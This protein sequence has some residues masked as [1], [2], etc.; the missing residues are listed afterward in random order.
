MSD[1]AQMLG[2]TIEKSIQQR[3]A[4]TVASKRRMD[5]FMHSMKKM[6][7]K[8]NHKMHA[9]IR[10]A[11]PTELQDPRFPPET[12]QQYSDELLSS[13]HQASFW[14]ENNNASNEE[15]HYE[16]HE[17]AIQELRVVEDEL[18]MSGVDPSAIDD[19]NHVAEDFKH[20]LDEA[21]HALE[22]EKT[23]VVEAHEEE[24]HRVAEERRTA[25]IALHDLQNVQ[26]RMQHAELN[27]AK[28][29]EREESH[30]SHIRR[31]EE[32]VE[33]FKGASRERNLEKTELEAEV[34]ALKDSDLN[35][36][37]NPNPNWRSE[38]SKTATRTRGWSFTIRARLF[39]LLLLRSSIWFTIWRSRSTS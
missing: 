29:M 18:I 32:E 25:H 2:D 23:L 12:G 24:R 39:T 14:E 15:S 20:Q 5:H 33:A 10:I 7:Q 30:R 13:D 19:L 4:Q 37:P 1:I 9:L 26:Q 8:T 38:G 36:D 22:H 17:D 31:L 34:R 11:H 3:A 35:P 28:A 6:F 27:M 16:E 21:A